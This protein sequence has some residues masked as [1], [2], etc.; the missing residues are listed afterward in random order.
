[1]AAVS[2]ALWSHVDELAMLAA[3]IVFVG[4][5]CLVHYVAEKLRR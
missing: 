5:G 1:M 4:A 3:C 2:S